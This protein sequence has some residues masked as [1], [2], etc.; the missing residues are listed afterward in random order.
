VIP[1]SVAAETIEDL[2]G[3]AEGR[4]GVD[5]PAFLVEAVLEAV[6]R[7]GVGKLG[8]VARQ[9]ELARL[10]RR[11][12]VQ[13]ETFRGSAWRGPSPAGGTS[14]APPSSVSRPAR[15]LCRSRRSGRAGGRAGSGPTCEG[16]S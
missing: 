3:P 1:V 7:F 12:R 10:G 2:L 15:A 5:D 13:R 8:G 4:L 16:P 6:P 14:R 9:V 11:G